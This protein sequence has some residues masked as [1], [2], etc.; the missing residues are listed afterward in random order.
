MRIIFNINLELCVYYQIIIE[1]KRS[2]KGYSYSIDL[3]VFFINWDKIYM[4]WNVTD[5][6]FLNS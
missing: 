5:L 3:G 4:E 6:K 2:D 1:G